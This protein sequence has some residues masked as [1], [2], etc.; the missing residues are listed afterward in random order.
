[1]EDEAIDYSGDG[2]DFPTEIPAEFAACEFLELQPIVDQLC[3]DDAIRAKSRELGL[4]KIWGN[5][6]YTNHY[7]AEWALDARIQGMFHPLPVLGSTNGL[8]SCRWP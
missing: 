4:E 5:P 7:I 3:D 8:F 6:M 1:M 2:Q